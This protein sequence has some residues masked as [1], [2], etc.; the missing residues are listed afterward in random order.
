MKRL[1]SVWLTVAALLALGLAATPAQA[2]NCSSYPFTLTNGQTADASQVMSNFN[3]I[4][5]CANSNLA[6]NGANSDITGITGLLSPLAVNQGGT[7]NTTGALAGDVG[8]TLGATTITSLANSKLATMGANTLKG[9][10]TGGAAAPL[11]LTAAQAEALLQPYLPFEF[12][13]F[14]AGVT[15]NAW[16]LAAY[17]PSTGLVLT[18][19]KSACKVLGATATGSTTYTLKDNGTS[20]G[21]AV[22]SAGTTTCTA[23]ITSS[24][25][26]VV[27]GHTLSLV[28]PATG[29]TTLSDIGI[30]FGGTRN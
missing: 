13:T 14:I 9:N 25:Y 20:I 26:T 17:V 21:T 30:T 4:L 16:N 2:A 5:S 27:S 19:A 8:G 23:T 3:A 10:N 22:V 7:G 11:D 28:G 12:Y 24:P 18:T 6:K 1:I 29:D 15:G